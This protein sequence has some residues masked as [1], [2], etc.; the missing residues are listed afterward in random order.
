ME[1]EEFLKILPRLI[2]EDDQVKGAIISALSGVVATK[3]DVNRIIEESNKRFEAIKGD[4]SRVIE[5]SNKRFEAIRGDI[6]RVIEES[7]KRFEAMDKRFEAMDKRFEEART[8]REELRVFISTVSTRSGERLQDAIL[9]LLSDKLIQESIDKSDIK[10]EY[11]F[12][13][14]GKVYYENYNTDIDVLIQNGKT[15]LIEI[16]NHADNRDVFDLLKKGQLFHI[17]FNKDYDEL[18]LVCLEINQKNFEQALKQGVR[19]IAGKVV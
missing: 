13:P 19:I 8:N 3:D 14:E 15:I 9:N 1:K 18:M 7:N 16:K 2:R 5:E 10:R 17:Q 11:L 4:I 6:T 12:D